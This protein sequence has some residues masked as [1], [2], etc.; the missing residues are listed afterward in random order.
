MVRLIVMFFLAI[1]AILAVITAVVFEPLPKNWVF[2]TGAIGFIIT[3]VWS[4][5]ALM[6]TEANRK[7]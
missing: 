5:Y 7:E 3:L 2:G 1:W 6:I 4:V